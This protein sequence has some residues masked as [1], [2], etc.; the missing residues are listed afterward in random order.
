MAV[1]GLVS[2]FIVMVLSFVLR[3]N[4]MPETANGRRVLKHSFDDHIF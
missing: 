1:S 3:E 4:I 2:L